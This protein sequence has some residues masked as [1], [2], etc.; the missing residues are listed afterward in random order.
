[1]PPPLDKL[2][3]E[4]RSAVLAGDHALT[5][6]IVPEYA[7]A[8]ARHWEMLTPSERATSSLPGLTRELLG[9]ARGM[10]IVQRAIAAEQLAAVQRTR[11]YHEERLL[12]YRPVSSIQVRA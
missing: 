10:T 11:R 3:G 2:A 9:W 4:L 5:N 8:L 12:G 6:R 7:E 1:M